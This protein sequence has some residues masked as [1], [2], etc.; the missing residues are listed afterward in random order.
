MESSG[1]NTP[2]AEFRARDFRRIARDKLN[3]N[4]GLALGT[5]L[6]FGLCVWALEFLVAGISSMIGLG[7]SFSMMPFM[8]GDFS[9][10]L[11]SLE[12]FANVFAPA[13][14]AY[15]LLTVVLSLAV[16]AVGSALLLGHSKFYVDL[17]N[18]KGEL[19]A[20]F[21]RFGIF[22]KAFGLMLFMGLFVFLWS[23][24]LFIPG[25][26][27]AFRYAMAPYLMAQYPEMGIRQAVNE[28]KRL[29]AGR[30]W[31]LFCLEL[32]FIGW[33]FLCILSFGIGYLWLMPYMQTAFAAFY[34][35]CSNQG[36]P[37]NAKPQPKPVFPDS[38]SNLSDGGSNI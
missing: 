29:M 3:G 11:N 22:F 1:W 6:L 38:G 35:D 34:L 8:F 2:R 23:L 16:T 28:S 25:I 21:S 10:D 17:C 15:S 36:I 33:G 13:L 27:A 20:L 18:N 14:G 9:Y 32:S 4:W 12:Q 37:L 24:L 5:S 7:T 26:I 19:S 30:K 31:R